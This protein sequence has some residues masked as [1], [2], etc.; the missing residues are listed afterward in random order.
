VIDGVLGSPVEE[1]LVVMALSE[2]VGLPDLP[3]RVDPLVLL[4]DERERVRGAA[5]A[6]RGARVDEG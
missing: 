2:L 3:V 4:G 5:E 1:E 6:L